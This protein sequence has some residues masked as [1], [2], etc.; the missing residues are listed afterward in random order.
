MKSV[1]KESTVLLQRRIEGVEPVYYKYNGVLMV[2]RPCKEQWVTSGE[3]S[4]SKDAL[5]RQICV[6][7]SMRRA[8]LYSVHGLPISG[9]EGT[10]RTLA[11]LR[12]HFWW[13]KMEKDV[14][15]WV[16]SCLYCQRRKQSRPMR[17]GLTKSLCVD[18]P[19]H[20]LAYDIVGPL[21]ETSTGH[22]WILTVIDHF[23][24]FPFAIPMT[25]KSHASVAKAL[26][27][28]VFC[29]TGPSVRLLSD[30]EKT[31]TSEVQHELWRLLGSQCVHTSGYQPS[32]NGVIERFHRWLNANL[33]IFVNQRKDDWDDYLDSIL[34]AYR[35]SVC[36]STG[37]TPF[38]LVFGRKAFMPP[39]LLYDLADAQ[40]QKEAKRNIKVS[41]SMREAYRF[42]RRRQRRATDNNAQRRDSNR[43]QVSF[44]EGDLVLNFDPS[45]D[46]HGPH[47]FQYRF[48]RPMV[49]VRK[50]PRNDNLYYVKNPTSS[51]IIKMNVNRLVPANSDNLDLGE[52]LGWLNPDRTGFE[53]DDA[54]DGDD[55]P[56]GREPGTI[57]EG[58]MVA[59]CVEPDL[60]EKLPFSIGK[61]L[62]VSEK[63]VL[64][65]H[66][67]GSNNNSMI[68]TWAPGYVLKNENKRY[69]RP[70][71]LHYTHPPYTNMISETV[72][73]VSD[74]IGLPFQL[75]AELCIPA[76]VLRAAAAHPDVKF[77][78]PASPS[79]RQ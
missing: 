31:F 41:D 11:R 35:T 5:R 69:Y 25:N 58:D 79:E 72:L 77:E 17:Q 46:K 7:S 71:P 37:Y 74:V 70:K 39:D 51:K 67:Y 56:A 4:I 52:P 27:R 6:P 20:T 18:R 53:Q 65:I 60:A 9:H 48:G 24:R 40:I 62:R 57:F 38:E 78:M 76:S 12:N 8:V 28:A 44:K 15:H 75:D 23:S 32:A 10:R 33:S 1:E 73:E 49:V 64:D 19:W 22:K 36:T 21:P 59:L 43:K 29:L 68:S 55:F 54:L 50:C 63:G 47:K 30:C 16:N 14:K 26:H 45:S 61:V 13:K 34:Y 42:V 2:N 3:I 66:W